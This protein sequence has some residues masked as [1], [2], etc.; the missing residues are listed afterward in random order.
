MHHSSG[1]LW[2][3]R[4]WE[5]FASTTLENYT[6]FVPDISFTNYHA[7][8]VQLLLYICRYLNGDIKHFGHDPRHPGA[9]SSR[10]VHSGRGKYRF[11]K[12][13]KD[14]QC[15]VLLCS[16]YSVGINVIDLPISSRLVQSHDYSCCN[17]A[18]PTV[19]SPPNHNRTHRFVKPCAY[20]IGCTIVDNFRQICVLMFT[21]SNV[22]RHK[23][24]TQIDMDILDS[25]ALS[26]YRILIVLYF[27]HSTSVL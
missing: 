26:L 13:I 23:H 25:F 11:H 21:I 5:G 24:I 22:L 8:Q 19:R 9:N 2:W 17:K 6:I 4:L 10:L 3:W 1:Q 27:L 12:T 15:L 7:L 14:I 18:P 20:F 16:Y